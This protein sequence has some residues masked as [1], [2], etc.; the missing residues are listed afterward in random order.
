MSRKGEPAA[1]LRLPPEGPMYRCKLCHR[2]ID[3][4]IYIYMHSIYIYI[5]RER[6]KPIYIY[7]YIYIYRSV[8]MKC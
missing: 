7:I 2:S 5:Y 6:E 1:A 4:Y 8:D 3:I